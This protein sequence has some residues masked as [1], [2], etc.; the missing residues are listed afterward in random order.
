MSYHFTPKSSNAKTGPI[1]VTTSTATTCPPSCPFNNGGGCY[2][3]G[4]PLALHWKKVTDGE[5]GGNFDTLCHQV[6]ALPD[7]KLW[8]HNQAGDL[9]GE[10]DTIDAA[11][12]RKLVKANQ[13][14][15]GFT[16]THKPMTPANMKL[17]KAAN[18]AGFTINL[19]ANNLQHADEL[20]DLGVAPVV[21]VVPED[22]PRMGTTPAGRKVA[23]CPA[24]L[25]DTNCADCGLCASTRNGVVIGFRAHGATRRRMVHII[26]EGT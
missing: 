1:P 19:S 22:Y 6:S 21:A 15:C 26:K 23:V 24:Q 11:D 25:H 5:R 16:Y 8:R 12:L 3:T 9:P 7:G 2:A 13:G 10:G 17:V 18:K 20:A 14:K 4:G